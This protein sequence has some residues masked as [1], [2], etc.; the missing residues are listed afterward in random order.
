MIYFPSRIF[1]LRPDALQR[2]KKLPIPKLCNLPRRTKLRKLYCVLWVMEPGEG[3]TIRDRPDSKL[4]QYLWKRNPAHPLQKFKE[5]CP[6]VRIGFSME[7]A[8]Q[9]S[10]WDW[11]LYGE[12][13]MCPVYLPSLIGQSYTDD[14]FHVHVYD[15]L[16]FTLPVCGI[17]HLYLSCLTVEIEIH[18]EKLIWKTNFFHVIQFNVLPSSWF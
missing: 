16:L 1:V 3:H 12:V 4:K 2:Y 18:F 5:N 11:G 9:S 7:I 6:W 8:D 15:C 17:H 14:C 10:F 13:V